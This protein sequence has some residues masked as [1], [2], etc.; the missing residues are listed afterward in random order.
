MERGPADEAVV[1]VKLGAE[2]PVVTMG[3]GKPPSQRQGGWRVK[4]GTRKR[5]EGL[6]KDYGP[7]ISPT[8]SP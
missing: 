5:S 6:V 2:E 7:E 1:I 8:R 3:E 4:G